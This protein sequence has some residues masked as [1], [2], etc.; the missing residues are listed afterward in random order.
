MKIYTHN[1]LIKQEMATTFIKENK[2]STEKHE[3]VLKKTF[4]T[5]KNNCVD[6]QF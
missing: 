5:G 1:Q 2:G 3:N 4:S 6:F